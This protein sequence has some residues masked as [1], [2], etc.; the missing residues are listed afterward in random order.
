MTGH[1]KGVLVDDH[2]NDGYRL[3]DG[4]VNW[5]KQLKR[6]LNVGRIIGT[7]GWKSKFEWIPRLM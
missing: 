7:G 4:V 3:W 5:H 2:W 1:S 6:M